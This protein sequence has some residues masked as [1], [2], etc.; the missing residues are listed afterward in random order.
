MARKDKQKD[1]VEGEGSYSASKDYNQRT[2][3]FVQSGK[4]D[5]A[6]QQ[7]KPKSEQERQQMERAEREGRQHAKEEDPAL[8]DPSKVPHEGH[9]HT[10]NDDKNT[11]NKQ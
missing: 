10:A 9:R 2:E 5:E 11:G 4:A 8:N 1:K 6:A 7:S 3:K